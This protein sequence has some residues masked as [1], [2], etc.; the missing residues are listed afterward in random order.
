ML[1]NPTMQMLPNAK[2]IMYE[3]LFAG[4]MTVSGITAAMGAFGIAVADKD[5]DIEKDFYASPL[6]RVQITLGYILGAF[7]VG[8]LI[9][10]VTLLVAEVFLL[11][12]GDELLSPLKMLQAIGLLML[13]SLASSA[14][15]TFVIG[16]LK[17]PNQ[18]AVA[19]TIVGTMIGFVAGI[20][21]PVG[22]LPDY[23]AAVV[24]GFPLSNSAALFRQIFMDDTLAAAFDGAPPQ[25]LEEF[26]AAFGVTLNLGPAISA[27]ILVATALVF[28]ALSAIARRRKG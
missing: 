2:L 17:T 23:A 21:L 7:V 19:S 6:P 5:K 1:A 14:I 24:K 8:S 25:A 18:F 12:Q 26:R 20:Y 27:V 13:T 3:W 16:F 9:S 28:F 4:L 10:L 15:M 22:T 11:T